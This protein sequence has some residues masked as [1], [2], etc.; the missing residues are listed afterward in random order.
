MK[1]I[2]ILSTYISTIILCYL[3]LKFKIYPKSVLDIPDN[4]KKKHKF[5]IPNLG[6][7]FFIPLVILYFETNSNFNINFHFI[8][9]SIIFVFLGF[10]DDSLSIDWFTRIFLEIILI[11]TYILINKDFILSVLY[12][13]DIDNIVRLENFYV[14]IIFTIFCFVALNNSLNFYDGINNQLSQFLIILFLFF[15]IK[16]NNYFLVMIIISLILFSVFNFQD[17]VFFGSASVYLISFMIF[18]FSIFYHKNDLIF[19]DEI[20]IMLLYPGLDMIRLFFHRILNKKNP[21]IGDRN[22]IHHLINLNH[23]QLKVIF[24]NTFPVVISLIIILLPF[25]NLY[26]IIFLIFYY[27]LILNINR[28]KIK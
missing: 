17:K 5:P 22:H 6:I 1:N 23:N 7:I 8:L 24:F 16:T 12:F 14:S 21:F 15:F 26:G 18:N 25:N 11:F 3:I 9:F 10:L 28:N 19:A 13:Q 2:L 27:F 4:K 20:F